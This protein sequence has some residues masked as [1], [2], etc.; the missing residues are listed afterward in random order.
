MRRAR[1]LELA[2]PAYMRWAR[3]KN[4]HVAHHAIINH[5]LALSKQCLLS[6]YPCTPPLASKDPSYLCFTFI[7]I[8]GG[9]VLSILALWFGASEASSFGVTRTP[10]LALTRIRGGSTDVPPKKARSKKKRKK[11]KTDVEALDEEKKVIG[12][13]MR[14]KDAA[15]ALGDAIR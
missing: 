14:E 10:P 7:M 15:E 4:R 9:F 6:C 11:P 8:R 13:A 12:E 2:D 3:I 1:G 5:A